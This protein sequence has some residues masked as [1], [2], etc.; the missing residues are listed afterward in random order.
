MCH[1]AGAQSV[2]KSP[3]PDRQPKKWSE[4]DHEIPRDDDTQS[5]ISNGQS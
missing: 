1:D 4:W 2:G 3:I 5:D